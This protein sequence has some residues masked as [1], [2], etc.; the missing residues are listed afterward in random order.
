MKKYA[1]IILVSYLLLTTA[2]AQISTI[3]PLKPIVGDSLTVTYHTNSPQAKLSS[4]EH[5]YIRIIN[6]LQDGSI[7]KF[8]K[9]LT[10]KND[11]MMATFA[12]PKQAAACKIEFY[13]LNKDDELATQNLLV[14]ENNKPVN[15]AYLD[16]LF[17]D[18]PDSIFQLEIKNHPTHYYAYARYINVVSMINDELTG[19]EKVRKILANLAQIKDSSDVGL[20]AAWCVGYAKTGDLKLAKE[21][22]FQ[23]FEMY[24]ESAQTAFALSI[25]NYEYYKISKKQIEDDVQ[26]KVKLIFLTFPQAALCKDAIVFEYLRAD[27]SIPTSAFESVILPLYETDQVIYYALTNLAELYI[28]R[29]ENL[30]KAK[31]LILNAIVRYQNADIQHQFRLSSSHYQMYLPILLLNL[32]KI[33]SLQKDEVSAILN[34]SAAIQILTGSNAEGNFMPLLLELRAKSY[35]AIGNFNLALDD[36]KKMYLNGNL[37]ALDKMKDLFPLCNS[38]HKT[39]EEFITA[40]KPSNANQST[41]RVNLAPYFT[42]TD[43]KGNKISSIDL[44]GKLIVLNIWGIGCGPCI[45]E[46][47]ALNSLV[48]LYANHPNVVFLAIT[49]DHKESL[50]KFFKTHTFD[51]KVI[52]EVKNITEIFNTNALPVHMVIGKNGEIINR[53]LGA[54]DDIKSFL[55][56]VIDA[57]L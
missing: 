27:G 55:K 16:A 7:I 12:L 2:F 50:I 18:K 45:A 19:K 31:S 24:P 49:A 3:S 11:V 43:L 4:Q 23:L 33:N 32:A 34:T 1:L 28:S 42:G 44:K 29:N 8:H 47:P 41:N 56:G 9:I 40:L 53:S 17:S 35:A 21:K 38:K 20:L 57:N 5:I 25:Y 37:S 46:M 10:K 15:G 39:I 30:D 52:N 48:K 51:Y 14:Y 36:Y 22:L 26:E 6:H 54:R 13:T